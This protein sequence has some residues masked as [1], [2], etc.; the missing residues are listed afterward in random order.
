MAEIKAALLPIRRGYEAPKET[1]NNPKSIGA[2]TLPICI[3]A[4]FAATALI[5]NFFGTKLAVNAD[6]AGPPIVEL[7]ESNAVEIYICH[8]LIDSV[9]LK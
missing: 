2:A 3:V 6:L 9:K 8:S 7:I 4:V 5:S 1:V